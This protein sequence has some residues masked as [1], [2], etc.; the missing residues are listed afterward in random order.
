MVFMGIFGMESSS[1][2]DRTPN[3]Q[4]CEHDNSGRLGEKKILHMT[5][6]IDET[7][8]NFKKPAVLLGREK[9][10]KTHGKPDAVVCAGSQ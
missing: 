5:L 3:V 2:Y 4:V 8:A 1:G 9:K 10:A 6:D 7:R